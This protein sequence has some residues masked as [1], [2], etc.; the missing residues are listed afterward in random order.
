AQVELVPVTHTEIHETELR[1]TRKVTLTPHIEPQAEYLTNKEHRLNIRLRTEV[2]RIRDQQRRTE[3][4]VGPERKKRPGSQV[5]LVAEVIPA[6]HTNAKRA[7][8][9]ARKRQTDIITARTVNSNPET[10]NSIRL[11]DIITEGRVP[12]VK[13]R[14]TAVQVTETRI[15]R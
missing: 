1:K 8:H 5:V 6:L 9:Q 2:P 4:E 3:S 12:R 14:K 11:P 13:L 7:K 10:N 15:Q